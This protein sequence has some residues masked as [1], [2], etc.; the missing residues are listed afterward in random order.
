MRE[1]ECEGESES[2]SE[3][4]MV[5]CEGGILLPT[6]SLKGK[7]SGQLHACCGGIRGGAALSQGVV[8]MAQLGQRGTKNMA[9]A[10]T[11]HATESAGVRRHFPVGM[12]REG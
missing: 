8:C 10:A 9:T 3:G 6:W 2:E 7:L 5:R 1:V 11:P 12:R 4:Q